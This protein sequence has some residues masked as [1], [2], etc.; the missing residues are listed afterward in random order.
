MKANIVLVS[1]L[2]LITLGSCNKD[3]ILEN[4]PET[5]SENVIKGSWKITYY[6]DSDKDE[7]SHFSGYNFTFEAGGV[8]KATNG[9]NDYLGTWSTG[10]DDSHTELVISFLSP[11]DFEELSDD[12]EV[13]EF[14]KVLIK[15]QDVSGGDGSIDYLTFT[16]I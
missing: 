14:S 4:I 10:T 8:L 3:K 12:W 5:L 11:L 7:T 6:W 2:V 1:L 9:T 16:K 13:I 15:L